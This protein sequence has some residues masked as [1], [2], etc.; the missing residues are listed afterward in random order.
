MKIKL[1]NKKLIATSLEEEI[2]HQKQY[3]NKNAVGETDIHKN[4]LKTEI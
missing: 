2:N 4:L 1:T 3:N